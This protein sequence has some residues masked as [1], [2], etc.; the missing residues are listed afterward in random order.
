MPFLFVTIACG[1][2]SGFHC[3]VSSG[4][5]SRQLKSEGDAQYVGYGAML[6]E[7]FLATLVILACAAG[8]GLGTQG[9]AFV[10]REAWLHHYAVWGGDAGLGAKLAPFIT[11]S[12]NMISTIGISQQLAVAIMGV[13]V[14]SF[15]ATTLDSATRL[16]R[17]VITELGGGGR[18]SEGASHVRRS[19]LGNRFVATTIA[20]V[21]AGAL[22]LSDVFTKGWASAGS[23]GLILWPLFG[24]TNQLLGGLALLVI[25]VWLVRLKRP[26]WVTAIPMVFMLLMTGWAITSMI[27]GFAGP[28]LEGAERARPHL[29]VLSAFMLA[30]EIWI[31]GEGLLLLGRLRRRDVPDASP[32]LP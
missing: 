18:G 25:T 10:G 26:V 17:Y 4:C 8:I 2:I 1:A 14:A 7:G 13:F 27:T 15:A 28:V 32:S 22:A 16:Q 19:I 20:V 24:A 3:L 6:T 12:A 23:G 5:S 9:G 11:G 21:T 29:L 31:V 30:L